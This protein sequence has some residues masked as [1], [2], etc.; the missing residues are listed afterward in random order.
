[1]QVQVHRPSRTALHEPG[2]D[3]TARFVVTLT[4]GRRRAEYLRTENED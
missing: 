1:M 4:D 2:L 3:K